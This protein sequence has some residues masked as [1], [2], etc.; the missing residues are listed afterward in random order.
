[1]IVVVVVVVVV[2]GSG[3]T[4]AAQRGHSAATPRH[5]SRL[6]GHGKVAFYF[7]QFSFLL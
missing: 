7:S 5:D 4:A 3:G 1:M 6:P 2:S